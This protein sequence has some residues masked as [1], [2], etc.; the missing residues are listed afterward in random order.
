M[1]RMRLGRT[2]GLTPVIHYGGLRPAVRNDNWAPT[3]PG[4][5]PAA[6]RTVALMLQLKAIQGEI[7]LAESVAGPHWANTLD[8]VQESI[9]DAVHELYNVLMETMDP[10]PAPEELSHAIAAGERP[11]SSD[12]DTL[13]RAD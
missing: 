9:G 10:F 3:V 4:L 8:T 13:E 7:Q 12:E 6:A 1:G 11:N 5:P 2:G